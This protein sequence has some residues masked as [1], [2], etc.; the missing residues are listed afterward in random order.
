MQTFLSIILPGILVAVLVSIV[1]FFASSETAFLSITK[2]TLRQMLKNDDPSK[3]S[4][5]A[6]KIA[7]LKKDTD[8]LL[9]LILIGI[10]FVT[11][12]A[13]GLAATVAIK[14]AGE[15]GSAY[16]TILMAFILI[17]FGEITPKTFSSV[18]PVQAASKFALPL[19]IL[20]KI[21]F[22]IVWIFAKI[23]GFLTVVLN[24]LWKN[25][26][27][28]IT[29]E[30]LKSLIAVGEN[31]GTLEH[32]EKKMLYK[33]F[34]FT[35]LHIHDIMR[36][37]SLVKCVPEN[38]SYAEVIKIFEDTGYSRIP[39][40]DSEN[41]FEN[42]IGMLYYKNILIR[43]R[44]QNSENFVKKC[45]NQV[46]FVPETLM[47]SELLAKFKKEKVN[48]AVAVDE[49]GS[50]SGIVTMDDIMR[51][52]FG[53]SVHEDSPELPPESRI[54][55]V[56]PI[57]YVI[58]G[59]MRLDDLN[60]LLDMDLDSEDYDTLAGWLLEHFDSLP[61]TGD[62]IKYDDVIYTVEEQ[63]QRRIQSVR[64]KLKNPPQNKQGIK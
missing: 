22:P 27:S 3:K 32:S 17:I 13:S 37:R 26:K 7:Y 19:I 44:Y 25:D 30:E 52:V 62:I 11:S 24:A 56:S 20:Q 10:N 59:D 46:I 43:S 33:I 36:H 5:P 1:A 28:L 8:K 40:C 50:N 12:L 14:I 18:Y 4:S 2:L 15:A 58:P 64:I 23:S 6:K 42:V 60:E 34:D 53:R 48:F 49:T 21:F 38:A 63:S 47:A 35:D 9:S 31:E 51:A 57:E 16:A 55:P 45:M 61:E 54:Q 39:V 29:E 41:G